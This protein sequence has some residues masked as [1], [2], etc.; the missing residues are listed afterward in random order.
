MKIIIAG[1]TGALGSGLARQLTAA[2]HDVIVLSRTPARRADRAPVGVRLVGWDAHTPDGW[3]DE[4]EGA[5][6]IVNFA[7]FPLPGE[8]FFPG[9]WTSTRK[10]LIWDSRVSAGRAVTEA[11]S[12][13]RHRPRLLIQASAIG[14]Y[15]PNPPGEV[16][17]AAQP[18]E[19]FLA[20]VCEAWEGATEGVESL[21]VRRIIVRTG[22]VLDPHYGALPRLLL[23]FQLF[24][25]GPMG[26]GRQWFSWIHP[27][28]EFGALVFLLKQPD[29]RGPVNLVAPNPVTN[30]ELADALGRLLHRPS[31]VPTPAFAL[32]LAFG[33]V[34]TTVLDGQRVRPRAL[35]DLG[36][37]FRFPEL[38]PA[39]ANL[40]GQP[41][42]GDSR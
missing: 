6:A 2:S 17:E 22:I 11:I 39:L 26:S 35:V 7:G 4:I 16:D 40:L 30:R 10:R 31:F 33:E 32:R 13:A 27:A 36:F 23:P 25:G 41:S 14:Y 19:D 38:E 1:G 18:G 9:R 24:A 3:S 42:Q 20:Q 21:G 37:A 12:Q 28:D 5:D 8:G 15:G 29:A 34:S